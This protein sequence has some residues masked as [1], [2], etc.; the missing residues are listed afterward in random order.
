MLDLRLQPW[1]DTRAG[2]WI[3]G[4]FGGSGVHPLVGVIFGVHEAA[5]F[6][7]TR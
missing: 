7:D 2:N 6:K 5:A 3:D 1:R 4:Y